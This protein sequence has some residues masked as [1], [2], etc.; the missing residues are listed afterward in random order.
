MTL[1]AENLI[2]GYREEGRSKDLLGNPRTD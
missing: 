2:V 1:F